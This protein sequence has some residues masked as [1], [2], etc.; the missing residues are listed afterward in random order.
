MKRTEVV[1]GAIDSASFSWD[2]LG[3]VSEGRPQLGRFV[4]VDVYRLLKFTLRD[5]LQNEY[6][7]SQT[8]D[9]FSQAGRIAGRQLCRNGV[10]LDQDVE[11][12]LDELAEKLLELK[13][14]ILSVE[15]LDRETLSMVLTIA[16]DL[17]CSGLP[18]SGETVCAFDEGLLAGA[19][20]EYAGYEFVVKE[21]DCWANGDRL[22]RFAVYRMA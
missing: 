9:I 22:C 4:P 14:G 1:S 20:E 7:P 13:I 8:D 5:V 11:D 10:E 19:L 6:G 18:V 3:D 17:D 21:L 15:K 16:E 2:D 12:F